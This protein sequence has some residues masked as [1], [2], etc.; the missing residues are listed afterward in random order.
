MLRRSN[1]ILRQR[2]PAALLITYRLC[3]QAVVS[4]V[5]SEIALFMHRRLLNI[6]TDTG[7]GYALISLD[8]SSSSN[9]ERRD[10][11]SFASG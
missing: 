2:H 11:I 9:S 1:F 3:K 7:P 6:E 5:L 10:L 8:R 4:P